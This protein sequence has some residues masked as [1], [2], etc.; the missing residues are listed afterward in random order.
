MSTENTQDSQPQFNV[1][2]LYIKDISYE[3]PNTPRIFRQPWQ[4]EL[5]VDV[6]TDKAPLEEAGLFEVVM[7][8]T[9]TAKQQGDTAFLIE[10]KQAG[11]FTAQDFD[12]EQLERVLGPHCASILYPYA[13]EVVS[14]TIARGGFPPL[15]LAPINFGAA[16]E[17]SKTN[18]EQ[19]PEE[20]QP[21]AS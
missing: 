1:Q 17:Q 19:A 20:K 3:A 6:Q 21:I 14:N 8:V 2:R 11:I 7:T 16:Y 13:R 18:D 10:V 15:V 5:N 4:P 9:V 12:E